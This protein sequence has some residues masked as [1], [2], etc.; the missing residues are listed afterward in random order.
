MKFKTLFKDVEFIVSIEE[1]LQ[2]QE[3]HRYSNLD[4]EEDDDIEDYIPHNVLL[5][6]KL[7]QTQLTF[8]LYGVY[9]SK[10][11]ED[12]AEEL[13]EILDVQNIFDK[14]EKEIREI[15]RQEKEKVKVPQWADPDY[16]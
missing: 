6:V 12:M 5:Y 10:D 4:A 15:I 8:Y 16:K 7:N 11:S 1:D 3:I 9:I 14:V 2:Y 13:A